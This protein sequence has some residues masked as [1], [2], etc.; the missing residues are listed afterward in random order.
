[1]PALGTRSLERQA[2]LIPELIEVTDDVIEIID[3]SI[4]ETGRNEPTQTAYFASG[5]SELE[6]PHSLHNI[7]DGRPKAEAMDLWPYV[8]PFGALSGHPDQIEQIRASVYPLERVARLA[9]RKGI[10]HEA[11]KVYTSQLVKEFVFKAFARLAGTVEACA[12]LRGY[13]TRWGGDWNGDGNLLDQ[14]FHDLPHHE[15]IRI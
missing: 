9:R 13:S 5:A 7:H 2:M 14:N 3:Y 12:R 15:F 10:S 1:M 11:A 6:W 4:I 8:P